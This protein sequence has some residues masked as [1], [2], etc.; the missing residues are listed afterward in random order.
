M[1]AQCPPQGPPNQWVARGVEFAWDVRTDDPEA[2]R[3]TAE[4]LAEIPMRLRRRLY[5]VWR[6]WKNEVFG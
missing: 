3:R 6:M 1:S 5:H 4:D 2:D